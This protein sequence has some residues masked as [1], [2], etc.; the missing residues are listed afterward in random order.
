MPRLSPQPAEIINRNRRI[1]F[2]FEGKAVQAYAGDTIGSALFASGVRIFS[3]SFKYHR[4]R[5]LLCVSGKCPNCLM[6][7]NGVP[8][9]RACSQPVC[10][11]DRVKS[12]HCWPSLGR[13]ALAL[14]ER[15]D[16]LL[17]VGFYY[18]T[19]TKP[20]LLWK[21]AEP[22]IRRLAGVGRVA[23]ESDARQPAGEHEYR[24]TDLA[25]V[26]GGPAG[27]AAAQAAAHA[28]INVVLIDDQPDLGGH[29]RSEQR[30][31]LDP[32]LNQPRPGF[33]IA[34]DMAR[35]VSS[36]PRIKVLHPAVAVGG[37][38]GGLLAIVME[39]R[40]IHLRATAIVV[41]TGSY[42]YPTLF[43]NN[44]LP[45]IM[46][47]S[48]VLRLMHLYGVRPGKR[49]VVVT[50]DEDGLAL[51]ID[52]R[53]AGIEVAA[54]VDQRA[55]E[56]QSQLAQELKRLQIP[57]LVSC[58]PISS[59][60]S[61]RVQWL[62]VAAINSQAGCDARGARTYACDLVCLCSNRAPSLE[63]LR[64]N[65]GTVRFD[66]ALE[67]MVPD[68]IPPQFHAAGHL[69]GI[70]NLSAI[71]LQG[72]AAGLEAAGSVRPLGPG[73][74][75][76]LQAVK[77]QAKMAEEEYRKTR[78]PSLPVPDI[79]GEK[80]FACLC[81]DVTRRDILQ[82]ISEGFDEMELLKRYTTASMGPCQGRMC[83]M[84][85]ARSAAA[86]TRRTLA[87]TGTT[88]SRPPIQPVALGV[89][90][91]PHHHPVKL[92][93]MHH[94]HLEAGARQMDMGEW[95]R[96]HTY[97]TP[98]LEW[99]AVRERVGLIDV[100]TL[101]KLDVRGRDAGRFLDRI[102]THTFSSLKVGR[103]RYGVMCGDDGII[104]D[105]GTVSRVDEDQ[106][107]IT[108]TTGNIEFVE[109]WL[110]WWLAGTS[111]CAHV[112]NVTGDFAAVNLAGPKARQ[113]LSKLTSIDLSPKT[114][115]YMDCARGE[116][117]GV[118]ALLMRI[119]FVGETGW[120]IHYPACHGEYLWDTLL[121][122]G[123]EFEIA[124]FGVEA[125]RLLRLEKKHVIVG[126]DTDA[127]SNPLEADME[128]VV[129]F[130]KEDFIGKPGLLAARERGFSNKLV[131]FVT[132]RLVE[133]GSVI[134]VGQKPVGR[135]TSARFSPTQKRC[136]GLA[137][138][139]TELSCEG[140]SVEIRSN[141]TA[142]TAWIHPQPFYDPEGVRL[143]E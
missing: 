40:L 113:T 84:P 66:E 107:Y 96:P 11:G 119:G 5:G 108:T 100:S 17:P 130:D 134:V 57:Y 126:Q 109:K 51:A 65:G 27:L 53:H 124:P 31:H 16:F 10:E 86:A 39:N 1:S 79:T 140:A 19:L 44:D 67:Q 43:A 89:L 114:F 138:V 94:K 7:V 41:A 92:T 20:R 62:D 143:K 35:Q 71:V 139:P 47:G 115:R 125:Q 83:L 112:S 87:E 117:A 70:Q 91:G 141:G 32:D 132:E 54:V 120:E 73:L 69:T 135:V 8:N 128:W 49:A 28:G 58:I 56:S 45:G 110:K 55:R 77:G 61:Q 42:E 118:P 38:E 21:L 131:G 12:Q 24:H 142:V 99:K 46:L 102:Y 72:R 137:W 64:Q 37:Y 103:I 52:L 78:I 23:R 105:D 68:A 81:E 60:G 76:E 25:I 63:I 82:A 133:E 104:L 101:G 85:V 106:F 26:G 36:H 4:P 98:E 127:L 9:V 33:E 122:A 34:R 95:K 2:E 116:V 30:A 18:K 59:R 75:D 90:A 15:V 22:I 14:I 13:D 3:R 80:Q 48:G 111:L 6:N 50:S 136:V 129:K 29:L 121:E 123:K 97:T 93:P 88:T 74:G